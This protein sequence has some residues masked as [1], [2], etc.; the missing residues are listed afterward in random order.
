LERLVE[1]CLYD[2]WK[3]FV[4][5]NS[6]WSPIRDTS[7]YNADR[8]VHS[9]HLRSWVYG[10]L[11]TSLLLSLILFFN[12]LYRRIAFIN[13]Y[14]IMI[15]H[16]AAN[17]DW[18]FGLV[19]VLNISLGVWYYYFFIFYICHLLFGLHNINIIIIETNAST[20]SAGIL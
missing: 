9:E 19:M 6:G 17:D 13:K 1:T 5:Q 14:N 18:R 11:Q 20:A 15:T 10:P 2:V 7:A 8:S 4:A 3:K 16:I 12:L